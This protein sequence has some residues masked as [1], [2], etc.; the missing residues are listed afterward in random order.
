MCATAVSSHDSQR[1]HRGALFVQQTHKCPPEWGVLLQWEPPPPP[2]AQQ[3]NNSRIWLR[4]RQANRLQM[5]LLF[6]CLSSPPPT[7]FIY[8]D[9]QWHFQEPHGNSRP[10][11]RGDNFL[12]MSPCHGDWGSVAKTW[13]LLGDVSIPLELIFGFWYWS[14]ILT[15]ASGFVRYDLT[16]L[17]ASSLVVSC[18]SHSHHRK[19]VS[20]HCQNCVSDGQLQKPPPRTFW[21]WGWG[22]CLSVTF[23]NWQSVIHTHFRQRLARCAEVRKE[24]GLEPLFLFFSVYFY[25]TFHV[26]NRVQH[27]DC[28]PRETVWKCAPLSPYLND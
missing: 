23:W 6:T 8:W 2:N 16:I 21:I 9:P 14:L 1:P 27:C 26:S 12:M 17:F 22:L 15:C 10:C 19:G 24:P 5:A 25:G 3:P 28:L 18:F 7:S 20:I 4:G 13:S 11:Q